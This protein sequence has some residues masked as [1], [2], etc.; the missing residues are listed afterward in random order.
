MEISVIGLII[1][2][3]S[4]LLTI[5]GFVVAIF[6]IIKTKKISTSAYHAALEAK[7]EIKKTIIISD[8]SKIIKSLQE[9]QNDIR[10]EKIE[11][12]Y[13]RTKDFIHSLI[14]IRQIIHSIDNNEYGVI[15]EMITQLRGILQRQLEVSMNKKESLDIFRI[16]QKLSEYEVS[17]S[18]LSV[19]MKFPLLGESK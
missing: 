4:S 12:A 19:K 3:F 9:I 13:L 1:T 10:T 8:L 18:E 6:Q 14:E 7:S 17:L 15:T 11:V 5:T 16:N 2:V